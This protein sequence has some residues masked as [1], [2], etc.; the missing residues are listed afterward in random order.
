MKNT[1]NKTHNKIEQSITD[2]DWMAYQERQFTPSP[3]AWEDQVLYF[4]MLDRFSDENEKGYIDNNGKP[5]T[6]GTTPLFQFDRDAYKAD[7][8]QWAEQGNRW[9]GGTLKGLASK[10]GYL[11]RLGVSAIWIHKTGA[12]PICLLL[13]L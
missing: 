7:R 5:V 9:L 11:K 6:T 13:L 2:I 3:A 4:L 10:I 8:G 1:D 12:M